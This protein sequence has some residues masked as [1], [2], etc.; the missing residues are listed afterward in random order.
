MNKIRVKQELFKIHQI[1]NDLTQVL[2]EGDY[3]MELNEDQEQEIV[4]VDDLGFDSDS[5]YPTRLHFNLIC[6]R[7]G[8]T[9]ETITRPCVNCE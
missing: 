9:R 5:D 7:C 1:L 6:R 3:W 2:D 4:E 8:R